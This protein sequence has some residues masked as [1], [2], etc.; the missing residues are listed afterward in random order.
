MQQF[1]KE[2]YGDTWLVWSH[3]GTL[4]GEE[5]EDESEGGGH[6]EQRGDGF[7]LRRKYPD[8]PSRPH[9]KSLCETGVRAMQ[10]QY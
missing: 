9:H 7:T 1:I 2:Q 5:E 4:P 6:E 3:D 10:S 8:P